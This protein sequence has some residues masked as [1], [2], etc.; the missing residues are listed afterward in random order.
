MV[1]CGCAPRFTVPADLLAGSQGDG[2]RLLQRRCQSCH[3]LPDPRRLT[4]AR[5]EIALE[6]MQRRVPLPEADWDR[7]Y[8]LALQDTA[9]R[10]VTPDTRGPAR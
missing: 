3:A 6:K 10:R 2:W 9:A 1:P 8:D 4:P 5:W 7:L